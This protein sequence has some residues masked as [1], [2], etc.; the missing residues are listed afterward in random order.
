[1]INTLHNKILTKYSTSKPYPTWVILTT[2]GLGF[3][4]LTGLVVIAI[5]LVALFIWDVGELN[6]W[7]DGVNFIEMSMYEIIGF[8]LICGVFSYFLLRALLR[9]DIVK[10]RLVLITGLLFSMFA[11]GWFV[12]FLVEATA[13][14]SSNFESARS[15][16]HTNHYRKTQLNWLMTKSNSIGVYTGKVDAVYPLGVGQMAQLTIVQPDTTILQFQAKKSQISNVTIGD[17]V[18]IKA[19][20]IDGALVVTRIKQTIANNQGVR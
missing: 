12:A 17:V 5:L 14:P 4:T 7:I 9:N 6:I 8:A 20:E 18:I 2:L 19:K 13:I 16:I 15:F 10:Y 1:M 3:L 11:G